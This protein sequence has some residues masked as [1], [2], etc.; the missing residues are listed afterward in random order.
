MSNLELKVSTHDLEVST[1]RVKDSTHEDSEQIFKSRNVS[2]HRDRG[3]TFEIDDQESTHD[4][5]VSTHGD[6][7][8]IEKLRLEVSTHVPESV[9][10]ETNRFIQCRSVDACS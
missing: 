8:S 4:L 2:T 1:H 5:E 7:I 6:S 3:L 10:H 9:E